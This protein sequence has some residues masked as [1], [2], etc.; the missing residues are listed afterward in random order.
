MRVSRNTLIVVIA[1][2]A[3]VGAAGGMLEQHNDRIRRLENRPYDVPAPMTTEDR[4][5]FHKKIRRDSARD[6]VEVLR[7]EGLVITEQSPPP[8]PVDGSDNA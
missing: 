8:P 5:E 6:F 7:E 1:G 2:G 3:L 4:L